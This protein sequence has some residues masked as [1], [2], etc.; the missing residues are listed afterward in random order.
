MSLHVRLASLHTT[1]S[2]SLKSE[3]FHENIQHDAATILTY[4]HDY[5][6]QCW[7]GL[8]CDLLVWCP[9]YPPK[10][11]MLWISFSHFS[12]VMFRIQGYFS[13][14]QNSK[15]ENISGNSLLTS[16]CS[17]AG[18]ANSFLCSP[19]DA[20][21]PLNGDSCLRPT[22]VMYCT[23]NHYQITRKIN[24]SSKTSFQYNR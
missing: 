18:A 16:S 15:Q 17:G 22:R 14:Q 4:L 12:P 3:Y 8:Y 6:H 5:P 23:N 1:P 2:L 19:G 10:A 7:R 24:N 9:K 13:K 11:V 21:A 20:A